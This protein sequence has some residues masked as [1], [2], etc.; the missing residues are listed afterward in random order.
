MT[1]RIVVYRVDR[2][3]GFVETGT[4]GTQVFLHC[5]QLPLKF[6]RDDFTGRWVQFDEIQTPRGPRA[7]HV[8][9]LDDPEP[10]E[11]VGDGDQA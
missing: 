3:Y 11:A 5:G 8:R 1:G 2:G 7:V 9:L 6:R 4:G 10:P